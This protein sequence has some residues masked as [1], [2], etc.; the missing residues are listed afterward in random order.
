MEAGELNKLVLDK[1]ETA[2]DK[3]QV[4]L[5]TYVRERSVVLGLP[6]DVTIRFEKIA[7]QLTLEVA[8]PVRRTWTDMEMLTH[9]YPVPGLVEDLL[10]QLKKR[11]SQGV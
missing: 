9:N 3:V 8:L 7:D 6:K 11:I 1:M 10:I 4:S 5:E 2:A